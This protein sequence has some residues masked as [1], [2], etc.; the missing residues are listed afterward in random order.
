MSNKKFMPTAVAPSNRFLS[1]KEIKDR[2]L[3]FLPVSVFILNPNG[4]SQE[5][6]CV[7]QLDGD[8]IRLVG[9]VSSKGQKINSTPLS[10]I[11]MGGNKVSIMEGNLLSRVLRRDLSRAFIFSHS[12]TPN[13][14]KETDLL[15]KSVDSFN[16]V[17]LFIDEPVEPSGRR[18]L[19]RAGD[20]WGAADLEWVLR[21]STAVKQEGES[22]HAPSFYDVLHIEGIARLYDAPPDPHSLRIARAA[23]IFKEWRDSPE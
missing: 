18:C 6:G 23:T 4:Q 21:N 14:P 15:R 11:P 13:D 10:L 2:A 19:Y 12:L 3:Q 7:P 22:P 9:G 8:V 16:R 17:W 20:T 5:L 1:W